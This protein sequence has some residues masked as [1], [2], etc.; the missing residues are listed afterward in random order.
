MLWHGV[1]FFGNHGESRGHVLQ[2]QLRRASVFNIL[3]NAIS[4]SLF[5]ITAIEQPMIVI[6]TGYTLSW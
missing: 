5:S 4:Y 1:I 2:D 3:I 6:N